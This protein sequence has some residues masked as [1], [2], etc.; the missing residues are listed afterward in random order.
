MHLV[1][2][3]VGAKFGGAATVFLDVLRAAISHRKVGHVTALVS[4]AGIREF[5]LP[6]GDNLSGVD[7]PRVDSS[8][9][10]KAWWAEHELSVRAR[11]LRADV[12]LSV[13]NNGRSSVPYAVLIHQS[14]PFSDEALRKVGLRRRFE[15]V[16]VKWAMRRS[17]QRA[18]Q[19]FVQTPV[20]C[21]AVSRS[22]GI[23][24]SRILP[25][26]PWT[27]ICVSSA[28]ES[29][30]ALRRLCLVPAEQRIL[31][32]GSAARYKMLSTLVDGMALVRQSIPSAALFLT[33]PED[34]IVGRV[35]GVQCIGFLPRDELA[36]VYGAATML[37]M[38][39]LTESAPQPLLE[40][41]ALGTPILAANRPYA[42]SIC[43]DAASYFDPLSPA[44]FCRA[45]SALLWN[46]RLRTELAARGHVLADRIRSARPYERMIDMVADLQNR[47]HV[48]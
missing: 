12:V 43:G 45:V 44:D 6:Q 9:V 37:A 3:A 17:C 27:E 31:Y 40:A 28:S 39:S 42:R 18:A 24:P 7:V 14:L 36:R 46:P 34:H 21:E 47:R 13:T 25:L 32:V 30:G 11:E 5:E 29:T 8:R 23:A 35:P 4:P 1:I 19:V 22:F 16:A 38:P 2:N 41:M 20:M 10:H 15:M 48:S 33:L 26:L